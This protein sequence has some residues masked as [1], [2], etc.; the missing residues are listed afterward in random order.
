MKKTSILFFMIFIC[1]NL[2]SQVGIR[3]S[4]P[5]TTLEVVGQPSEVGV[6]DGVIA[7]RISRVHLI[8]KTA[9][10]TNQ[11]GAIIYVTDLSGIV[12][13]QTEKI[14]EIGY[15][16]FNGSI[17]NSMNSNT[18]FSFGDT[19]QGFQSTDHNGWINLDGRLISTLSVTQ[20]TQANALGF[21]T[22]LPDATNSVLVQ[23]GNA[24]GSVS[25]SNTKTI[26][27]ANLP[28]INLTGSGTLA[29]PRF[30]SSD[31][32]AASSAFGTTATTTEVINRPITV[33]VSL[34]GNGT[35]L[36]ITPQSLSVHTYI[37]LG[38]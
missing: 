32:P 34:G 18:K 24:L 13:T 4:N 3:T 30:F 20:Q 26:S 36:D 29:T 15:Y 38:D 16:Y 8:A 21:S 23:N 37:Y 12:N 17:W 33:S 2:F 25:G 31:T 7:P 19:K 10:S 1:N 5:N 6:A 35:A 9:Y 11:T 14:T 27:Q 22:N 28:N